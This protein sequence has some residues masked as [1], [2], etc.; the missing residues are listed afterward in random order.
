MNQ[1]TPRDYTGIRDFFKRDTRRFV[2]GLSDIFLRTTSS[3]AEKWIRLSTTQSHLQKWTNL[4]TAPSNLEAWIK[5]NKKPIEDLQKIVLKL[6]GQMIDERRV[7]I[8]H[9]DEAVLFC[10]DH[11]LIK[12]LSFVEDLVKKHFFTVEKIRFSIEYDP[13]TLDKWVCA[14][15][16]ISGD[17][18]Q[19]IEW[20]DNFVKEWV[21]SVP[22]PER[23]MVR[24]SCDIIS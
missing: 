7:E 1:T 21:A 5:E 18:D 23:N 12:Y 10:A 9:D 14:D 22:Y 17:I 6:A 13:E 11:N 2:P 15:A 8:I 20:E 16:E 19:V 4:R 3:D 24:L